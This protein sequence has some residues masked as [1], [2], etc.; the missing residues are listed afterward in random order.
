MVIKMM[1][2]MRV[3]GFLARWFSLC[4]VAGFFLFT[5]Q[6]AAQS[7]DTRLRP[8]PEQTAGAISAP[9]VLRENLPENTLAYVRIP[10]FWG[11]FFEGKGSFMHKLLA[12][13]PKAQVLQQLRDDLRARLPDW[14]D[15]DLAALLAIELQHQLSPLEI[16][17]LAPPTAG[18]V[19]PGLILTFKT[20]ARD[21]SQAQRLLD[22]LIALAGKERET[23]TGAPPLSWQSRLDAEG[24]G[25]L[26]APGFNVQVLYRAG[27]Q[28]LYLLARA[29]SQG[30]KLA[31]LI[32]QSKAD[33]NTKM[34]RFEQAIDASGQGFFA[35]VDLAR[36]LQAAGPMLAPQQQ[37]MLQMFGLAEARQ[38][39]FGSGVSGGKG[40]TALIL[41]MPKT[42]VRHFLPA[43]NSGLDIA[44]V[45]QPGMVMVFGIPGS[46]DWVR[47][48]Q[49]LA[50]T[51]PENV[52]SAE[53]F[54]EAVQQASGF[55]VSEWL[56][57]FGP[58]FVY[59]SDTAGQYSALHLRS[60][61]NFSRLLHN[62]QTRHGFVYEERVVGDTRYYHLASPPVADD[63][64]GALEVFDRLYG[65]DPMHLYWKV[66]NDYLVL[67]N[68]PQVLIDREYYSDRIP[69]AGWLENS[70]KLDA[71]DAVFA[72][73]AQAKGIPQVYYSAHLR[74]VQ[75]LGDLIGRPVDLFAF[76]TALEAGVPGSGR[77]SFKL[78][79][80]ENSVAL[81]LVYESSPL[82]LLFGG[83]G[84]TGLA[85]IGVAAAI[86]IPA[87]QDYLLRVNVALALK[88]GRRITV[89]LERF[90]AANKRYP[91]DDE[92]AGLLGDLAVADS[93]LA[94]AYLD[95]DSGVIRLEPADDRF[96]GEFLYLTP[97]QNG[98]WRCT[99]DLA[100]K[101]LPAE[102]R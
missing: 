37:G 99:A 84:F 72:I 23:E 61:E 83:G 41:D 8:L 22:T 7:A 85:I 51:G 9:S 1:I 92:F 20:A 4:A 35:W 57:T 46:Q 88:E 64:R 19:D 65:I 82:E 96:S 79:S 29:G 91:D 80:G 101:F 95:P 31:R 78:A 32:N 25:V 49:M 89:Q 39:A 98:E 62:L 63:Q 70:Q 16:A 75:L 54:K 97:Q 58:E 43:I 52:R 12:S 66:E 26:A 6:S 24:E 14:L 56:D 40:R 90:R 30:M 53:E 10:S 44:T 33:A 69:L 86:A 34:H 21:I 27:Q 11:L 48:E 36:L 5:A 87:Y 50:L 38:L 17:V 59:I 81:E 45:G 67:A 100:A 71:R 60:P 74:L 102:C 18:A 77:Y 68:I 73:S 28:R 3:K 42:G 93:A 55:S 47:F 76:P 2:P 13:K 15:A 94:S